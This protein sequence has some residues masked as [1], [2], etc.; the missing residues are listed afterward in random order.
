MKRRGADFGRIGVGVP[1]YKAQYEFFQWWSYLIAGGFRTGDRLLNN[2]RVPGEV[3]IPMAQRREGRTHEGPF[4]N[5][6]VPEL[7]HRTLHHPSHSCVL[8]LLPL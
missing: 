1:Y 8:W 2:Q 6:P 3:P 7:N 4:L 5:S